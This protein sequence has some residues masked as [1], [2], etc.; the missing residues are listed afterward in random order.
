MYRRLQNACPTP[1]APYRPGS[2][3]Q[4]SHL[5]QRQPRPRRHS[6]TRSRLAHTGQKRQ[7]ALQNRPVGRAR[8]QLRPRSHCVS[9][10][11]PP[12]KTYTLPIFWFLTAPQ[13]AARGN[14]RSAQ[15]S[16]ELGSPISS[17]MFDCR[18]FPIK[19]LTALLT[20]TRCRYSDSMH[21]FG[22]GCC[23]R[24]TTPDCRS[25]HQNLFLVGRWRGVWHT[26]SSFSREELAS[27]HSLVEARF[28][29]TCTNKGEPDAKETLR[30]GS[31]CSSGHAGG[32]ARAIGR[33]GL[34]H[35]A[36]VA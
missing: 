3:R 10:S 34:R 25:R 21:S 32:C 16:S 19:H 30:D 28:Q 35:G 9:F 13:E 33:A 5:R 24:A 2:T 36:P 6:L 7:R 8:T 14:W 11:S 20:A 4:W 18:W 26:P 15:I 22:C 12:L 17:G 1:A 31:G 23:C 27:L 29:S